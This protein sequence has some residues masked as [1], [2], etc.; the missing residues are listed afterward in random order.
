MTYSGFWLVNILV[1]M[2]DI[3]SQKGNEKHIFV[4]EIQEKK[5]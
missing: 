3:L 5:C 1:Q 4:K 2:F